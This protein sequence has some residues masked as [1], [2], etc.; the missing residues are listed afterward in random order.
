MDSLSVIGTIIGSTLAG[1]GAAVRFSYGVFDRAMD[2]KF[3]LFKEELLEKL[4]STYVRSREADVRFLAMKNTM[5]LLVDGM[6][7]IR[8]KLDKLDINGYNGHP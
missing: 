6:R 2:R 5:D 1:A 7:I 3:L 8:Q 4:D